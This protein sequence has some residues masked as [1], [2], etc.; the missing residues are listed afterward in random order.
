MCSVQHGP[1]SLEIHRRGDAV[2]TRKMIK[3]CCTSAGLCIEYYKRVHGKGDISVHLGES[4][5]S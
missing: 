2:V 4:R 3:H 5:E 1:F